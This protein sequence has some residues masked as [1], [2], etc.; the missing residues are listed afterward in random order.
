MA[1]TSDL[2]SRSASELLSGHLLVAEDD[3]VNQFYVAELVRCIGCTCDVA[4]D[5]DEALAALKR[6]RYD[7]VLMDCQMPKMDGF[8]VAR[9]IRDGEAGGEFRGHLPLI[10]LTALDG[11]RE[12]CL[13]AGMD[14]YLVKP[15]LLPQL[16]AIL[17]R[18]LSR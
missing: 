8:A 15:L 16:Q 14:D 3:R 1:L 7:A 13:A 18:F 9:A 2:D 6:T 12:R 10:A 4:A 5:G 11:E 17:A